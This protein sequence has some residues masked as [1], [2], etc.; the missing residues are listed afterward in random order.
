MLDGVSPYPTAAQ[1]AS[2]GDAL[3]PHGIQEVFRFPYPA[4]AAAA[5]V[6]FGAL[7]FGSLR[8]S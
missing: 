8:G 1:I 4:G 6:P 2:A 3:G 5:M 7:P